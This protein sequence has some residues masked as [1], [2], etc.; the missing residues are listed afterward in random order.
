[1]YL[2]N[3]PFDIVTSILS[4]IAIGVGVDDAIHFMIRYNK[5][6]L[7]YKNKSPE[8]K[9]KATL[10]ETIRPITLTSISIISGMLVLFF[11][12]YSP[13]KYFGI[14][15]AV[16][17]FITTIATLVILPAVIIFV[18]THAIKKNKTN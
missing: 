11:A 17:L 13:I 1:M 6:G 15:L 18:E 16:A 9:V 4:S 2:A 5:Q 12:S 8:D 10:N 14:L 7:L 3:I